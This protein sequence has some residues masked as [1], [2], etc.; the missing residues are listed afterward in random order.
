MLMRQGSP[1]RQLRPRARAL[2]QRGCGPCRSLTAVPL[3][4]SL[5]L[6]TALLALTQALELGWHTHPH[7]SM[8]SQRNCPLDCGAQPST[9]PGTSLLQRDWTC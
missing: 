1:V 9:S 2:E 7:P 4:Y 3:A 8:P 6:P 5:C